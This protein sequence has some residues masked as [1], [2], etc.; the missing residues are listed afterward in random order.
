MFKMTPNILRNLA[1]KKATRRY[2]YEVREPFDKVRGE[3]VNDIERCIFCGTCEVK[4]PS[5]CLEVDKQAYKWNYDPFACVH[6][7][8][9]VDT[10]P[11]KCLSQKTQYRAPLTERLTIS[12]QGQPRKKVKTKDKA[13]EKEAEKGP[14]EEPAAPDDTP[15]S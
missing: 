13:P 8:V 3:L 2:P 14:S 1:V 11:A 9:C 7:G 10:C 12:L 6:C 5:R 15:A 4:C